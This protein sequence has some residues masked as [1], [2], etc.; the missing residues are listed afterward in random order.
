M[1]TA[2]KTGTLVYREDAPKLTSFIIS[3]VFK[4][5][6]TV[7]VEQFFFLLVYETARRPPALQLRN[8]QIQAWIKQDGLNYCFVNFC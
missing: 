8:M 5:S 2:S 6:Q 4:E 3:I 1:F 7:L